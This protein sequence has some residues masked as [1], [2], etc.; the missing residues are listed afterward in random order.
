MLTRGHISHIIPLYS[1][2]FSH[3]SWKITI[4]QDDH[5][6]V[7]H[8]I[9]MK[10]AMWLS[11]IIEK[12]TTSFTI[13]HH[14]M[15]HLMWTTP[16]RCPRFPRP[17][18]PG[19]PPASRCPSWMRRACGRRRTRRMWHD[20]VGEL[21]IHGNL[22]EVVEKNTMEKTMEKSRNIGFFLLALSVFNQQEWVVF[23]SFSWCNDEILWI[24]VKVDHQMII[25]DFFGDMWLF[26]PNVGKPIR[27]DQWS[28]QQ[29]IG[30]HIIPAKKTC[31]RLKFGCDVLKLLV[32]LV[33]GSSFANNHGVF[34]LWKHVRTWILDRQCASKS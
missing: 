1:P 21:S 4:I 27:I 19:V 6:I 17:L 8:E 10:L 28:F 24:I 34:F 23:H 31:R 26:N 25:L 2:L 20:L 5:P 3:C 7:H 15:T 11:K 12:I 33:V 29:K 16:L 22:G 14:L 30:K 32:D 9:T 13:F 18:L